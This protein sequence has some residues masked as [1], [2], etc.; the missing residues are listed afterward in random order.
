MGGLGSG[1]VTCGPMGGLQKNCT[2]WHKQT[3]KQTDG[4]GDSM[5]ESAQ[6]ANSVKTK[7]QTKNSKLKTQNRG[8]KSQNS[9]L[10]FRT[11]NSKKQSQYKKQKTIKKNTLNTQII[12]NKT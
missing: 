3:N 7:S 5:T 6:W 9:K 4:H 1:H 12:E 2:Q 10:K 8:P 11:Q